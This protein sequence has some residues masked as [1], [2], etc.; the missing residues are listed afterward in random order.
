MQSLWGGLEASQADTQLQRVFDTLPTTPSK[1]TPPT[2]NT[3]G[4][5]RSKTVSSERAKDVSRCHLNQYGTIS[6]L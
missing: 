5:F 4:S 1:N 6:L 3:L 2:K